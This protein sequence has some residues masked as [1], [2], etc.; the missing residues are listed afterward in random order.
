MNRKTFTKRCIRTIVALLLFVPL[1]SWGQALTGTKTIG[2]SYPSIA[3][4]ITALNTNGVGAGGVIFNVPA[5]YT[6]TAPVGGFRVTATG[7]AANPIVFQKSGSGTNPLISANVGVDSLSSNTPVMD[8]IWSFIGSDYVTINGIDIMDPNVATPGASSYSL[9]M[10]E[11][12][13]GFFK[14][15][16]TDGCQYNSIKNCSIT[17]NSMNGAVGPTYGGNGFTGSTGIFFSPCKDTSA[18]GILTP[19]SAAGTNSYNTIY[20]NT[21]QNCF[22]PIGIYGYAATASTLSLGDIGNDI[23]GSSAAT[24]NTIL[25]FGNG[26]SNIFAASTAYSTGAIFVTTTGL[27]Y[28]VAT[29]GNSGTTAPTSTAKNT[30]ITSGTCILYYM[31][32][33]TVPM[34]I[35]VNNQWNVNIS[36]NSLTNGTAAPQL[37]ALRGIYLGAAVSASATVNNNAIIL[38]QSATSANIEGI[39]NNSGSTAAS[40][41]VNINNNTLTLIHGLSPST[42][43]GVLN[44]QPT[45]AM[46]GIYNL[47]SAANLNI[48]NNVF[49]NDTSYS[50]SGS[51]YEIYNAGAVAS[52]I[53]MNNNAVGNIVFPGTT[54]YSGT[55]YNMY[56]T[57]GT[58]GTAL[59]ISNNNFTG[60]NF[61][62]LSSG[63]IYYI[64]QSNSNLSL[65]INSNTWT[66]ITVNSSGSN[67][68]VYN[69]SNTQVTH[70]INNNSIVTGYTRTGA[71]GTMY[72][73][74]A[75]SSS[76]PNCVYTMSGNNFSNITATTA[77]SGTVY[78]IYNSDGAT[79]PYPRKLIY[80][81]TFSNINYNTTG[82][83]YALYCSYLGDA[84]GAGSAIY[85]NTYSNITTSAG[86]FYGIYPTGTVS[87]NYAA[88]VYGNTV[89]G[90]TNN[91]ASA[92]T[93]GGYVGSG[94]LG[95][96][97]RQNK[98]GNITSTGAT[99]SVYGIYTSSSNP[100][101]ISNN[102]VGDLKATASSSA[103]AVNGIYIGSGTTVNLYYNTVNLSGTSTGTGFGSNGVYAITGATLTMNNNI[104]VNNCTPT[105]SGKAIA[106]KRSTT[107]LGTYA[108]SSNN[109]ILYAGATPSSS[110]A[111]FYDGTTID[112][113][114]AQYKTFVSPREAGSAT[115]SVVFIGTGGSGANFLQPDSTVI[116]RIE[117]GATN[118]TGYNVDANGVIR[119][120]NAGY[121]GA[122]S[123]PDIGAY[124]GN[125]TGVAMVYDSSN[126]D[127][128]TNAALV[129]STNQA[130]LRMRIYTENSYSPLKATRFKLNTAGTT[131]IANISN[132]RV[133]Y[134]GSSPVFSTATQFGTVVA[135]PNGTFYVTGNQTLLNGASY[136]WLTYDISAS[137]STSAVVDA[138]W[139]SV[140]ISGVNQAPFDGNPFGSTPIG[141]PLAGTYTIGTAPYFSLATIVNDLTTRGISANVTVN[142]PAGY[143]ELAPAT[144]YILGSSLL[145]AS[146]NA[147][148]TIKIVKSGVGANPLL[149]ANTGTS[150]STDAM[151]VLAGCDNV[152]INGIDLIDTNTVSATTEMEQGYALVKLNNTAPFDGCQRDTIMNCT[153]T[154]NRANANSR[155][156]YLNNVV[157]TDPVA[158]SLP[159]TT[160]ADL[161]SNNIII[162]N[163]VQNVNTGIYVAGFTGDVAPY[164]LWDQSNYVSGNT[165]F[166]FAGTNAGYGIYAISQ[167]FNTISNNT[168][169]NYNNGT[170]GA[171]GATSTLYGISNTGT[172]ANI[173]PANAT[174]TSNTIRLT[175]N[176]GSSGATYGI[177]DYYAGGAVVVNN[178]NIKTYT[179]GTTAATGTFYGAY[180]YPSNYATSI[181]YKNNHLDSITYN[182]SSGSFYG[183]YVYGTASTTT[184]ISGNTILS[185]T[186][187]L[188][189]SG[190]FYGFYAYGTNAYTASGSVYNFYNNIIDTI[191]LTT[192]TG[193]VYVT[194]DIGGGYNTNIYN[195]SFTRIYSTSGTGS[196]YGMWPYYYATNANVYNNTISDLYYAGTLYGIYYY[197]Y[198]FADGKVYNNTI[199]N[200]KSTGSS[201]Q[202][203]GLYAYYAGT[204]S[205]NM[206]RNK[207]NTIS[208][209]GATGTSQGIYIYQASAS[210]IA[211][212]PV[213]I[214]NNT[215]ADIQ[216][217]ASTSNPSVMGINF[218]YSSYTYN[219]NAYY[220]TISLTG[221]LATNASSAGVYV[222]S[223]TPPVKLANNI[224]VNNTVVSGTGYA[225]AIQRS[226][227]SLA[228][229]DLNSN[230]NVLY[231]GTP[232]TYHVLYNDGTNRDQTL[233]AYKVRVSPRE[234]S[235]ISENTTFINGTSP[236]L[237]NYLQ[238]DSTV[239]TGIESGAITIS[240]ITTDYNGKV[241]QGNTGY[242]GTGVATDI[243]AF[244]GNYTFADYVAPVITHTA[245]T[246]TASTGNRIVTATIADITGVPVLSN[247]PVLYYKKFIAG[248]YIA[249]TGTRT[250]GNAKNG[251][252]SF[253]I[254]ASNLGGLTLGDSVYYY[255]VAQDSSAGIN[256]GSYPSGVTGFDVNNITTAPTALS[257]KI[258]PGISGTLTVGATGTYTSLTNTGGAFDAINNSALS[259]NVVLQI[260]SDLQESGSIA[261]N[262]WAESGAGNY[263]LRI[264]PNSAVER[265]I[266]DTATSNNAA[267]IILN[268]ATRVTIDGRFNGSG[269]YLRFR[270]RVTS[271]VAF[272]FR[273]DAVRDTIM[274]TNMECVNNTT[275]TILFGGSTVVGGRGNDSNVVIYNNIGDT[276]NAVAPAGYSN[277]GISS[278]GTA[279]LEN[280]AN[281]VSFN[282]IYNWGYNAFNLNAVGTGNNWTIYGNSIYQTANR[283]TGPFYI[284]YIQGGGGHIIRKNSIG[285][286]AADRSGIPMLTTNTIYGVYQTSNSTID[287]IIDSNTI[288]NIN[289]TSGIAGIYISAGAA[290]INNNVIG[291]LQNS[292]DSI[293][294]SSTVYGI[295]VSTGV[296]RN[297]TINRNTVSNMRYTGGGT[298]AINGM[299]LGSYGVVNSVT[300]NSIHDLY[301]NG[302]GLPVSYYHTGVTLYNNTTASPISFDNNTIYN[303]I[304][305]SG[306]AASGIA[307]YAAYSTISF[308]RNKIYNVSSVSGTVNGIYGPYS[309][310]GSVTFANNQISLP[311]SNG[312]GTVV[313]ITD[314]AQNG[315]TTNMYY[316][317]SVF[318]GGVAGSTSTNNSYAFYRNGTGADGMDVRN[319]IFYNKRTGGTGLH[320]AVGYTSA[321]GIVPATINYNLMV[322]SD[323]AKLVEMPLSTTTGVAAWN[324]T[325]TTSPNANWMALSSA[326]PAQTLFT[327]T[328]A[329]NLSIVT[330]NA[331]SWYAN[332]K[333]IA[334]AAVSNDYSGT[335]R[336]TTIAG[337]ATDIGAYEF[338]TSTTPP[339]A[340]ASAAPAVNTTTNYTFAGRNVASITWGSA[341]TVPTSV[342]VVY[343]TGTTAPSLLASKTQFNSYYSVTPAG[344][345][346][347]TYSIA[348]S[349][350]S[351]MLG[352]VGSS[353]ATRVARYQSPNWYLYTTSSANA[354]TG[355]LAAGASYGAATLPSNFTGT[356]NS[357]PLPVKLLNLA[358]S[359]SKDDVLV[360]W[361]TASEQNAYMYEVERSFDGNKFEYAGE[362]KAAGN[363]DKAL[364][365]G[366]TDAGVFGSY[367][368]TLYYRLKMI[369]NDG[370][371]EYSNTVVVNPDQVDA[372]VAVY[373]NP[374]TQ[375]VTI[376]FVADKADSKATITVTNIV[377][378]TVHTETIQT[379]SGVNTGNIDLNRLQSGVYF[380]QIE[381][382]DTQTNMK[383]VKN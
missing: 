265:L 169:D 176:G 374:F 342:A 306:G 383:L 312:T 311:A 24:G 280:D 309:N 166:N 330:T 332:G 164:L 258:V 343:Y 352:N 363:S 259:G 262:N 153:V 277:T 337:G 373:P 79:S 145:N 101:N 339:S 142:V 88:N 193:T 196:M 49:I 180:V 5:F 102:I 326:V 136:F 223:L 209:T 13:Y 92:A 54:G 105:G 225:S 181:Q 199:T 323:T 360:S 318:V 112:S 149:Y 281:I 207:I 304:N 73:F 27:V 108:L 252:W 325:Y 45:G 282:N 34:G 121:T 254:N 219:G 68:F 50:T 179:L 140:L 233:A 272:I 139:D 111:I 172:T 320:Y 144:G 126:T 268:G 333:G 143:V 124:E 12:G 278:S 52:S 21:I 167:T 76:L 361:M 279:G 106:F 170:A 39:E 319:N 120:G 119:A 305:I 245:V 77:G 184:D 190:T 240:G 263:T 84:N 338:T 231:A 313:G 237:P 243:G 128:V 127:Q 284:I 155:G 134:T 15:S 116:T 345:T 229:Y 60:Y 62:T 212:M 224:I 33:L 8:G 296:N 7:T 38:K 192:N 129:G 359:K 93:Y 368:G 247:S 234:A 1:L 218:N 96:N 370:A 214:Y 194:Y 198:Y 230:N 264:V 287:N 174:I 187:N 125:L 95:V 47:A 248:S 355:M 9:N 32:T 255:I 80:N 334:V 358:A 159:I 90:I 25:S 14:N 249:A 285:G 66:N 266:V 177:Y 110:T 295:Y 379:V 55:F 71:A 232:G 208:S 64:Y 148:K 348:M 239:A 75:G 4:A 130:V 228:T 173:N 275:G 98:I 178:N 299:Y 317:N 23:G 63:T 294:G 122:A 288:A 335:S 301:G 324:A 123:N 74:Y 341:G 253:T 236:T 29:G 221:S 298:S 307:N 16:V 115:E 146:L 293:A 314:A 235:S 171:V 270:N 157:Y 251:T 344:G 158:T 59:S 261:L 182:N 220:N 28:T 378:Q 6:E 327:D 30:A 162:N 57:S 328:A 100:Y 35:F 273:N 147:G 133:Y 188:A 216:A 81:N 152:T 215:I 276:L 185:L 10:M 163:T 244:E 44:V 41:T 58:T 135:A 336:S 380:I 150:T 297:I 308:T 241:R 3:A 366:Y 117:S 271:G 56:N 161:N 107:T 346:G 168:I 260:T 211:N 300:N 86:T 367:T 195:N 78:M 2:T 357:N 203:A 321:T 267:V 356:N 40:N 213:N 302:S 183:H 11:Y 18:T 226:G 310:F 381:L 329:G 26:V 37:T 291:G 94:T 20:G 210:A 256:L 375:D 315:G 17:L 382:N 372:Q 292:W 286:A 377:G 289:S 99:G 347:Y 31:H 156:I 303:I 365:Y 103:S 197:G 316:N 72:I 104:I 191:N 46:Y 82:T 202:V 48:N 242:I 43:T 201:A 376:S 369:D 238:P 331:N 206:Y 113:T 227:A 61:T 246:N 274:Y 250:A 217:P 131:N 132:A 89:T 83:V 65:N 53:N 36:F 354:V 22:T 67:Y 340:T 204:N 322:V 118:I 42:T 137:A 165:I 151:F 114:F 85:N 353:S 222:G 186:K 189:S 349:Y 154:L 175:Q 269:R 364:R 160:A 205:F 51:I 97:F 69:A 290:V 87:P 70:N 371:A 350:D 200:L 91:G 257:Y 141:V 283:T 109:N 351:S 19:T 138:R 362:V